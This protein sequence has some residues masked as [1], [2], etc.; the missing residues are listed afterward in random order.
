MALQNCAGFSQSENTNS[1]KGFRCRGDT[2]IFCRCSGKTG[3]IAEV[4]NC[5]DRA[6]LIIRGYRKRCSRLFAIKA[7]HGMRVQSDRGG[8]QGEGR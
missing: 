3:R 1:S 7:S 5:G 6:D 4:S 2:S 8:L